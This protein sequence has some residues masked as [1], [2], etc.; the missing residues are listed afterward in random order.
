MPDGGGREI[1]AA[2]I[3]AAIVESAD[4][5]I[6]SKDLDGIVLTWNAAAER[7]YGYPASEAIGRHISFIVPPELHSE[8]DELLAT[9][10]ANQVVRRYE[11]VR[12][13]SDGSRVDVS[14]SLAPL[15][16]REGEVIAASVVTR[17]MSERRQ[18]EAEAGLL[19]AIV[20]SCAEAIVGTSVEGVVTAWNRAAERVFGWTAEEAVGIHIDDLLGGGIGSYVRSRVVA[21]ETV[22]P[23]HLLRRHRDG[24]AIE[25]EAMGFPIRSGGSVIGVSGLYHD[26]TD[27]RRSAAYRSLLTSVVETSPDAV[28]TID[29]GVVSSW[30]RGAE[31][32]FGYSRAEAVGLHP[33]FLVPERSRGD[34]DELRDRAALTGHVS[35]LETAWLRR[36][37]TLVEVAISSTE[38]RL[39]FADGAR[40]ALALVARDISE[41]RYYVDQLRH[42]AFHDSLTGMPNR[43]LLLDRLAYSIRRAARNDTRLLVAFIDLDHFKAINDVRG[44]T[45]GDKL[46]VAVAE[47]LGQLVR[48]TDTIARFGGDEFVALCEYTHD[49]DVV[50]VSARLE[51]AFREA[52]ALDGRTEWVSAS[53]GVTTG[54]GASDP[55][56]LLQEADTA[57][58]KAKQQGRNQVC[59]FDRG[60]AVFAETFLRMSA[61]LHRA[62]AEDQLVLHYQPMVNLRDGRI[63]GAEALLRW[64]DPDR[65]LVG[66]AQIIPTAEEI[67]LIIP[68]GEWVLRAAAADAA[69]WAARVNPGFALHVNVSG[70]QLMSPDLM[71][72]ISDAAD[73]LPEG[74]SLVVELTESALIEQ[75][76]DLLQAFPHRGVRLAVDDFGTGFAALSNLKAFPVEVVKIDRSF[77]NDLPDER[78]IALIQAILTMAHGFGMD[79]TA[80]GVET[81]EQRRMLVD[82]GC[83]TGQGF[84]YSPAVSADSFAALLAGPFP[85]RP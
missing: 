38:A 67:G 50:V 23:I 24:S 62:L 14:I 31:Q 25:L 17:D 66:P 48:G 26:R 84:L 75:G 55:E 68:I 43:S 52:F 69:R 63:V 51:S 78:D 2:R 57:M 7:L 11:T 45:A 28:M 32:L 85:D 6:I 22:G 61:S 30:N 4:D 39:E 60:M 65:G 33:D 29:D 37:G 40:S 27:E 44:H 59:V 54:D 3:L 1:N 77:V 71:Q 42:Q 73:A 47:R 19:A 35:P 41:Q 58:Y 83:A 15:C 82:L 13:R 10:A 64:N 76:R 5:A 79:V 74:M 18:A 56:R 20:D 49:H 80:E 21:G 34:I 16:D 36:D 70:R 81:D 9:V 8:V 53:I 72:N 12:V 46:L